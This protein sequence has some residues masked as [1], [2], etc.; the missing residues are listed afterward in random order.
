MGRLPEH[1]DSAY[2]RVLEKF[3]S[4]GYAPFRYGNLRFTYVC[5]HRDAEVAVSKMFWPEQ[6]KTLYC[7]WYKAK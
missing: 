5:L 3:L 7:F 6:S 2:L 1:H 4:K